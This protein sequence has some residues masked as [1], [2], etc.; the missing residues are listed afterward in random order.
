[1]LKPSKKEDMTLFL[2][3]YY[4]Q[5]DEDKLFISYINKLFDGDINNFIR[6]MSFMYE[7]RQ[8]FLTIAANEPYLSLKLF[9]I[10]IYY[11]KTSDHEQAL[12]LLRSINESLLKKS[13]FKN[14][15]EKAI[16]HSL[17]PIRQNL[18]KNY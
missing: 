5:N 15:V 12:D 2:T 8:Y 14:E 16:V 9:L 10:A 4:Q 6:K 11:Q 18:D 1:V 7:G 3:F 17:I 13:L